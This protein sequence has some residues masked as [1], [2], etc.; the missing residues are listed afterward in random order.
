MKQTYQPNPIDKAAP[1][2]IIAMFVMLAVL[3]ALCQ[4]C[5]PEAPLQQDNTVIK[6][7]LRVVGI[8]STTGARSYDKVNFVTI[9]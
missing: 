9:K 6:V 7:Q 3:F 2:A 1:V 5:K 4:A 8:D